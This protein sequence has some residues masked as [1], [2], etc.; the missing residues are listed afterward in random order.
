MASYADA[1]RM[2]AGTRQEDPHGGPRMHHS[3]RPGGGARAGFN[4]TILRIHS[5]EELLT[6]ID[7]MAGEIRRFSASPMTSS[8]EVRSLASFLDELRLMASEVECSAEYR[9]SSCPEL[10]DR[11][12]ELEA[13]VWI[14]RNDL[15]QIAMR[16][17]A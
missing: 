7:V 13:M 12:C 4:D 2:S 9:E 5:F 1:D 14:L 17:C 15:D 3:P 16:T 11:N 6:S 10:C 8:E